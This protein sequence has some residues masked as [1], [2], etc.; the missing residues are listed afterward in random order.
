[1]TMFSKFAG[2]CTACGNLIPVG[3]LIEWERGAGAKHANAA[4]CRTAA[5][6]P[7][8]PV[9]N[10]STVATML[11]GARERG[12]KFPKARFLAPNNGGE[13][14]LSLAGD[15]SKNPGAV[16]VKVNGDY[17][18]LVAPNGDTRGA[19]TLDAA[20]VATLARIAE[21]P[22]LCAKE[23]AALTCRCSFCG[24]A[25]TD[26]GSVEVGYG[27]ICARKWNL[28]HTP[29][30]TPTIAAVD[31]AAVAEL[32]TAM[33]TAEPSSLMALAAQLAANA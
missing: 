27:P 15:A 33:P 9:I 7:A 25:L 4:D 16:Y 12:L 24:L 29:K 10:L 31:A 8:V 14:L 23:Y 2:K 28:P 26:A 30:G 20:L 19:L 6:V 11:A 21:H 17:R 1:M 13:L 3:T 32:D 22:A 18:G 5:P